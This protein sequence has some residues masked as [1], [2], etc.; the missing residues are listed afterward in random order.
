M[1][2]IKMF[3]DFWLFFGIQFFLNFSPYEQFTKQL[4]HGH[5][6]SIDKSNFEIVFDF[7]LKVR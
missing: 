7:S 5:F 6:L 2:A 3:W 1:I 4:I